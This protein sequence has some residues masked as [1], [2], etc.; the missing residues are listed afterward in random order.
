[1][2]FSVMQEVD[3]NLTFLY[4]KES[5]R[6]GH[7]VEHYLNTEVRSCLK[8]FMDGI[9]DPGSGKAGFEVFVPQPSYGF[10]KQINNG[11]SVFTIEV[12][13]GHCGG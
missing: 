1:M 7:K 3:I 2:P 6:I 8:I 11:S 12:S 4:E 10:N 5:K 13:N 9:M